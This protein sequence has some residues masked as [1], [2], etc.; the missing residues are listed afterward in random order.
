MHGRSLTRLARIAMAM[1][2]AGGVL[3][4][5]AGTATAAGTVIHVRGNATGANNGA[6]WADAYNSLQTAL[7]A[8]VSGDQIWVAKGTYPT[9]TGSDRTASFT[10]RN[11]VAM[12]GGFAGTET[13]L[14]KRNPASNLTILT[15]DIG[16]QGDS[17]D[18]AMHVVQAGVVTR[19]A[20]LDGFKILGGMN[21]TDTTPGAGIHVS[22][23]SPTLRN[24]VV[25]GNLGYAGGGIG[26]ENGGSP[27]LDRVV[28]TSNSAGGGLGVGGGMQ[29]TAS[30]PVL[31]NVTFTANF[32]EFGG[33]IEVYLGSA[34]LTNVTFTGNTGP[35]DGSG[36]AVY[37]DGAWM[38][39]A[40]SILWGETSSE[41]TRASGTLSIANSIVAGGCPAGAS[42]TAVHNADPKLGKLKSNGG[43]VP[44]VALGT[45]S[46][47]ID[48]GS[49]ATC[50]AT[51]A[52][53]VARPQGPTCDMGAFEVRVMSFRSQAAYDGWV[54]ESSETSSKGGTKNAGSTTFRVGDDASNRQY[55]GVVSFSTATLPNAATVVRAALSVKRSA[56]TGTSPFTTHGPLV[57]DIR[58]TFFGSSAALSTGDFQAAASLLSAGTFA[59]GPSTG[60]YRAVLKTTGLASV[61]RTSTTQ[62]RLRFTLDDNNAHGADYTA[63]SSGNATT[64][65]DRPL[66]LVYYLP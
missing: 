16:A 29:S 8:A 17:S 40:D 31:R 53:G 13:S 36:N 38:R 33:G 18:N 51:D 27:L 54:L 47:A 59:A 32:G 48:A 45:G 4:F 65:A 55:R 57:T 56:T 12:Y 37:S 9:T 50:A 35:P 6:S 39:I 22:G 60:W 41:V 43:F 58:A 28:I 49:N 52:R 24:L 61:S 30:S 66:L 64:P 5:A 42:C 7:G 10:L 44:T 23:G 3:P 25:S 19:S 2:L 11:G 21:Y 62:F 63:F 1:L 26:V 14:S 34:S 46:A 20:I 15:G